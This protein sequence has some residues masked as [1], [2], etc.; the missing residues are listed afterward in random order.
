M[1]PQQKN[2]FIGVIIVF[3]LFAII[4]YYAH[5]FVQS[6]NT[7]NKEIERLQGQ[8]QLLQQIKSSDSLVIL[9]LRNEKD[10]LKAGLRQSAANLS[11]QAEQ[12]KKYKSAYAHIN[13]YRNLSAD[14]T[15]VL[16][17]DAFN[18]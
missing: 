13:T 6:I 7:K 11:E 2:S 1:T 8:R 10:S 12:L 16:F 14:S 17:T 9:Q 3:V 4:S 18:Y 5:I 15:A